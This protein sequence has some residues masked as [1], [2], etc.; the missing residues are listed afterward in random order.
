MVLDKW[1]TQIKDKNPR[2]QLKNPV[3]HCTPPTATNSSKKTFVT[4]TINFN[5][6]EAADGDCGMLGNDCGRLHYH[7]DGWWDSWD[8]TLTDGS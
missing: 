6:C 7:C 3:Q 1:R 2:R 8:R 5:D 4:I